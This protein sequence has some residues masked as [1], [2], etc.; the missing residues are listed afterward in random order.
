MSVIPTLENQM[1]ENAEFF[2]KTEF[3]SKS[4]LHRKTQT[5]LTEDK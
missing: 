4:E 5:R 2:S 3:F 1:Q